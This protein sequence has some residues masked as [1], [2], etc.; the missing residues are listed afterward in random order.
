MIRIFSVVFFCMMSA[1]SLAQPL[2][3]NQ[4]FLKLRARLDA[5]NDYEADVFMKIDIPFIKVPRLKGKLYF[6]APD[7]MK[8]ERNGG[9]SILP[10]NGVNL[11]MNNLVPNADAAVIDA[12]KDVLNGKEV[13]LIKVIPANEQDPIILTKIWVDEN[14]ILA[15]RTETTT[16]DN[17]T[18]KMDLD[19]GRFEKVGLPDKVQFQMD[20][21]DFKLPKGVTMD[22]D[23]ETK[24]AVQ[25]ATSGGRKKGRIEIDY[26]DYKVN[27]G[28]PDK[29]FAEKR[30]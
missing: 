23:G 28:I 16:R 8:L 15:M 2:T 19:Y 4:L 7:K 27:K 29:V 17:G 22:Y 20:V 3:A 1:V 18:V 30:Q 6:K 9:I 12:G 5:V 10:R 21:K 13:R 26:Q 25:K 24:P 14:K 11:T